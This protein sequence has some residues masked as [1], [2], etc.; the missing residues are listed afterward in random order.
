M[1]RYHYLIGG[2]REY[3]IDGVHKGFDAVALRD[4]IEGMLSAGDKKLFELLYTFYDVKNIINILGGRDSF[5]VLG[6]FSREEIEGD[7]KHRELLPS[8]IL[9]V[10]AAYDEDAEGGEDIDTSLPFENSLWGAYYSECA[11]SGN[12]FI[13]EWY[14]FDNALRNVC[15]A[16]AARS[17][18]RPVASELIGEG[19]TVDALSRNSAADFGLKGDVGFIDT[20]LSILDTKDVVEKERRMDVLRWDFSEE[21][22]GH[23]YFSVNEVL[24]YLTKINILHRW[25]SLGG[26]RGREVFGQLLS[27]LTRSELLDGGKA[28]EEKNE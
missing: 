19:D 23:D 6:N 17:Q 21:L 7:L 15:T 16:Y 10:L 18:G 9:N 4:E 1:P 28:K 25:A 11:A 8:F 2:L 20:L 22:L 3:A 12:R 26:E 14:T 5:D 13:R 27:K 24:S